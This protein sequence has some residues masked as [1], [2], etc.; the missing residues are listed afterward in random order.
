V[1]YVPSDLLALSTSYDYTGSLIGDK[2]NSV[3]F[4]TTKIKRLVP[5]FSAKIR[6]NQGIRMTIDNVLANKEYQIEDPEFDAFCDRVVAAME[7][8]KDSING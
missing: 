2:T 6:F 1:C 7:K 3:V 4:D 8:V 5:G